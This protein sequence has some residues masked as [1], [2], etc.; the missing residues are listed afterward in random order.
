MLIMD[1]ELILNAVTFSQD[2]RG[3]SRSTLELSKESRSTGPDYS[4]QGGQ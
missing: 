3:G 1:R 4:S 2:D